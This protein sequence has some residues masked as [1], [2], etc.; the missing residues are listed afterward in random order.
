[1]G[2]VVL[3]TPAIRALRE[4]FPDAY[5]AY[6]TDEAFA[7]LVR[8]NPFL[9][10]VIPVNRRQRNRS[11]RAVWRLLDALEAERFDLSVDFHRRLQTAFLTWGG[12]VVRRIGGTLLDTD[13]VSLDGRDYAA[14]RALAALEPLGVVSRGAR[15]EVFVSEEETADAL[16]R[17][18]AAGVEPGGR[19]TLGVFP[20]AGW[21]PRAW[22]P[23]RFAEVARRFLAEL[24]GQVVVV[25]ASPD[26]DLVER[27]VA[28]LP[29]RTA[30]LLDLPLGTL[31]AA[32]RLCDVFLAND[33]GPMHLAV[34]VG[35]PTVALFGPGNFA[36]FAPRTEPHIA[37]REPIACSP[38]KQFRNHCRNNACMQLIRVESV[39]EAVFRA[40]SPSPQARREG[41]TQLSRSAR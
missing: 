13:R 35:T 3:T 19:P 21:R 16:R 18:E 17:L 24:D 1:M 11:L 28:R 30:R 29:K 20:G 32:I 10:A 6:L 23:E 12:G 5:L 26:R 14:D 39:V 31:A 22:M 2:D 25:G 7:P 40:A 33:T 15:L 9:D 36:R 8:S 4:R 38:C 27:V 41:A 37:L 34:A